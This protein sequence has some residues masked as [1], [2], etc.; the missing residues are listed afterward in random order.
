MKNLIAR[1]RPRRRGA[2][3]NQDLIINLTIGAV[4]VAFAIGIGFW[5][6]SVYDR[7]Q[8]VEQASTI[9]SGV[10]RL[11][12]GSR[13]FGSGALNSSLITS[14]NVPRKLVVAGDLVHVFGGAIAVEGAGANFTI[15]FEN[16]PSGACA[17][18]AQKAS[19]GDGAASVTINGSSLG[20][21]VNPTAAADACTD[22]SNQVVL[23]F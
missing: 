11:F 15:T 2:V 22:A 10:Q 6:K 12:G 13:D 5:L 8:L 7:N 3:T 17:E 16:L 4:I 20:Q 9:A 23:A 14:Q 18:L 19:N 1:R 21:N